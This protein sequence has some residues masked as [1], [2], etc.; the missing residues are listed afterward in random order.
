MDK[1]ID[2]TNIIIRDMDYIAK[3]NPEILE[4]MKATNPRVVTFY[5]DTGTINVP[6]VD[7]KTKERGVAPL[8]FMDIARPAWRDKLLDVLSHYKSDTLTVVPNGTP[9][10]VIDITTDDCLRNLK[11]FER[12]YKKSN[13]FM[14]LSLADSDDIVNII[15]ENTKRFAQ[16]KGVDP[17]YD[18]DI[19]IDYVKDRFKFDHY[20]Q[21]IEDRTTGEQAIIELAMDE[22]HGVIHWVNT[23]RGAE[24]ENTRFGNNCLYHLILDCIGSF[25]YHTLNLGIDTFDYKSLWTQKQTFAKGFAHK[26]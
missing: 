3:F 26:D 24:T 9:E 19:L 22:E 7:I 21:H 10:R 8:L 23:Y 4:Y 18:K 13:M 14:W 2:Q 1:L 5:N 12:Y 11:R 15:I 6:V 20:F 25:G 17:V 16:R